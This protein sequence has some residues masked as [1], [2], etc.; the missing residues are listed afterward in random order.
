MTYRVPS[1]LNLLNEDRPRQDE[2]LRFKEGRRGKPTANP[3]QWPWLGRGGWG[4]P[5]YRQNGPTLQGCLCRQKQP[6]TDRQT[7]RRQNTRDSEARKIHRNRRPASAQRGKSAEKPPPA[8]T[9]RRRRWWRRQKQPD[10]DGQCHAVTPAPSPAQSVL[11]AGLTLT[12]GSGIAGERGL[13]PAASRERWDPG[14]KKVLCDPHP[15]P[16]RPVVPGA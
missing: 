12:E 8:K 11:A 10:A 2:Q 9:P 13:R 16:P 14:G 15:A 1:M 3:T 6:Q 7:D 5:S 4:H